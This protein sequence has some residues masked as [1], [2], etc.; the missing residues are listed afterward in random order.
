MTPVLSAEGWLSIISMQCAC[1]NLFHEPDIFVAVPERLQPESMAEANVREVLMA[2][3]NCHTLTGAVPVKGHFC[4]SHVIDEPPRRHN[5][6]STA[7]GCARCGPPGWS[8]HRVR[9][10]H[11][12]Q[13]SCE[14]ARIPAPL[15]RAAR[16][17]HVAA[18]PQRSGRNPGALMLKLW[19]ATGSPIESR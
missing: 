10:I 18:T 12:G 2:E 19:L 13:G 9:S 5:G 14:L 1:V 3:Q 6:G 8:S 16:H 4:V 17:P 7:P 15:A 11:H